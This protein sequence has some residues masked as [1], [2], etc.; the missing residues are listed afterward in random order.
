MAD[1]VEKVK[2]RKRNADGS[3]KPSK[4]VAVEGDTAV[5]VSVQDTGKWAPIIASTPGLSFSTDTPL[6]PY[7]RP[8]RNPPAGP[9]LTSIS[10]SELLLHSSAHQKLDYTAREEEAG[11]A[12]TLLKHYVGVYDPE[13]GEMEVMEAR[14]MVVRGV[15]RAHQAEAD[16]EMTNNMREARNNLGQ[17]FGTKKSKKAIASFT[18]NAISPAL[19]ARQQANGKATKMDAAAQAMISNIAEAT[20]GMATRDELAAVA[21]A[22]KPRPKPNLAAQDVK[23]VYTNN[24]LIGDGIMAL[25]PV[26]DWATALKAKKEIVTQSRFVS[27]RIANVSMNVEKL[28]VMRYMLL[29]LD[30][31]RVS[32]ALRGGERQLPM[33]NELKNVMGDM[34]EAVL[35]SWKR[36]Y[37]E[38]GRVSKFKVDLLITHLCAMAC[39]VDNYDVDVWD[40]MEDLALEPKQMAQYFHEIGA[41]LAA[42]PEGERRRLGL[43]KAAA[44]QRRIAKLRL[45]LDFPR[46]AFARARK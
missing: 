23:D 43:D 21:D 44:S 7:T 42:F 26:R 35:E 4:R 30:I 3:S 19:A 13:T 15:V 17:T 16:N 46:V 24:S 6:Q 28:K 41:K 45:P 22:A 20:A 34:P 10:K 12:D 14:R 36:K 37:S 31:L 11:G 9:G 29:S 5:K 27:H 33:R 8:R 25:L 32:K 1:K 2:K 18:E 40:L 38:S 39:V